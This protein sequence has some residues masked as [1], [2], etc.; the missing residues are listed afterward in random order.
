MLGDVSTIHD[1]PTAPLPPDGEPAGPSAGG[2]RPARSL[3]RSTDDRVLAGVAGGIGRY[4]GMDPVLFRVLFAV[5]AFFGGAGLLAYVL[6]WALI[7]EEGAVNPVVDRWVDDLRKRGIAFW[8]VVGILAVIFWTALFQAWQPLGFGP[9]AIAVVILAVALSKRS[10]S[11]AAAGG[12]AVVGHVGAGGVPPEAGPAGAGGFVGSEATVPA[13]A[14]LGESPAW[15]DPTT[16]ADTVYD[17]AAAYAAEYPGYTVTD[18]TQVFGP[19]ADERRWAAQ[20]RIIEAR[21]AARE[22]Q[23][24]ARQERRRRMSLARWGS[25]GALVVTLLVLGLLDLTRGIPIAAYGWA[26]LVVG[27]LSLVVGGLFRRTPWLNLLWVCLGVLVILTFGFTSASLSDGTGD[28]LIS[29]RTE[30]AIPD[31]IRMAFGRTTVDLT[32]L[33]PR[34]ARGHTMDIRQ[35]AGLILL[36]VPE[37]MR[38]AIHADVHIGRVTVNHEDPSGRQEVGRQFDDGPEGANVFTVNAH[39]AVGAIEID[40]I[41]AGQSAFDPDVP[42]DVT[43]PDPTTPPEPTTPAEPA[44]PTTTGGGR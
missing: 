10:T 20:A 16:P 13:D 4:F 3:R 31:D 1:D 2:G 35:A 30:A 6:G 15:S 39:V 33:P 14:T 36:K 9:V 40:Y 38:V 28:R 18:P 17:P 43:P 41:P 21:T 12:G 8:I 19:T 23:R 32:E 42:L 7:P 22:S 44:T 27:L 37:G 29:P 11:R 25:F 5:S 34:A 24:A 26:M